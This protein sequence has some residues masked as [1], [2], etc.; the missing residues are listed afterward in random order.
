MDRKITITASIILL[1][2]TTA[3]SPG[4]T[5]AMAENTDTLYQVS[6]IELL[7]AGDYDG[8]VT[9]GELKERGDMGLGTIDHLDGEMVGVDGEFYTVRSDGS[10]LKLDNEMTVPFADVTFFGTDIS[11]PLE[12]IENIG[13]L[14]KELEKHLPSENVIYAIRI[15]ATFP[16]MKT[17]AVP[18]QDPPY[19]PL[20][21]VVKNQTVFENY[22]VTG[23]VVGF[24]SPSFVNGLNV[25]GYHI[26]FI[27]SDRTVGGHILDMS[28]DE[29][30]VGLDT[31]D[32]YT[33]DLPEESTVVTGS[34][35]GDL[36][37]VEK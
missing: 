15:D 14:E 25:P 31:T 23:T 33:I 17:R 7:L 8:T 22:N 18:R 29:A 30:D 2:V 6:A 36:A 12:D 35:E 24:W 37:A 20:V 32:R 13:M 3:I 34:S 19:P 10:V 11:V 28:I 1:L 4:C 16:Y 27:S 21:E 9:I 26:H 5:S